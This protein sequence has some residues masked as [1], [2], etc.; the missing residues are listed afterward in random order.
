M[1]IFFWTS[2]ESVPTLDI[3]GDGDEE[4]VPTLGQIGHLLVWVGV[5]LWLVD[6]VSMFS[7]EHG[8]VRPFGHAG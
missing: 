5:P 7:K 2:K 3:L 6:S 4:F 1:L 8:L